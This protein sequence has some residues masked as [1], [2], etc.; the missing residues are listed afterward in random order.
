MRYLALG[1]LAGIKP[2]EGQMNPVSTDSKA[3]RT[4]RGAQVHSFHL[5]PGIADP[6]DHRRRRLGHAHQIT[7]ALSKESGA[8]FFFQKPLVIWWVI[9][10]LK[11]ARRKFCCSSSCISISIF[12]AWNGCSHWSHSRGTKIAHL[13]RT[14]KRAYPPRRSPAK[15]PLHAGAPAHGR[16][17]STPPPKFSMPEVA[18]SKYKEVVMYECT[19]HGYS[20]KNGGVK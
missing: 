14:R 4:I 1:R 9:K 8:L 20:R 12:P 7:N 2:S 19:R 17:V 18:T 16:S 11:V 6:N 10:C 5:R 15:I 3:P 13:E